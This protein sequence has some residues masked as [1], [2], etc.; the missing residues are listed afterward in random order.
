MENKI[1]MYMFLVNPLNLSKLLLIPTIWQVDDKNAL[2]LW[3]YLELSR[4]DEKHSAN[5]EINQ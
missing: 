4:K 1:K 2:F 5:I 3:N